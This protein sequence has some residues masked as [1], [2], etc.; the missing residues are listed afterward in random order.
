MFPLLVDSTKRKIEVDLKLMLSND[1]RRIA[2][3]GE[4]L[5]AQDG[6]V[7][8]IIVPLLQK[9]RAHYAAHFRVP[10][11]PDLADLWT[12]RVETAEFLRSFPFMEL[13]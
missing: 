12:H 10:R 11:L 7:R 2:C 3:A 13:P 4:P 6:M 9:R 5:P 8:Y 1:G